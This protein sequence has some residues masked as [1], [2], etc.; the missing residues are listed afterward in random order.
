MSLQFGIS[1]TVLRERPISYALERIVAHGYR[2]AEVWPWHLQEWDEAPYEL[3]QIARGLG[4]TLTLHAWASEDNPLSTDE[5]VAR[6]ARRQVANSLQVAVEVG[7][8]MVTVHPG[9]REAED[10]PSAQA[11]DRLT[12]WLAELDALAG[13]YRLRVGLELMEK[14]PLEFFGMPADAQRVMEAGFENIGLTVDLAHLNTHDDPLKL[15]GQLQPEW[16]VHVHL[17]D[18]APWRVHLPLG[19]GQM[20]IGSALDALEQ[21]YQGIVSI[22]GSQ[23]GEAE[24]LLARNQDYL[25][26]LG[27]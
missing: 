10:D 2:S 18:N 17:S 13:Q 3:A 6:R 24:S 22:E 23:P 9:R 26:K 15:L 19:E 14:L 21:R 27:W 1:T 25:R 20:D 12:S 11:W 16:I 5:Y 7:A 4:I 8:T